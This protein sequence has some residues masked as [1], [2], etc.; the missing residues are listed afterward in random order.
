[1]EQEKNKSSR[2][3]FVFWSLAILSSITALKLFPSAP[4][5]KQTVKMLTQDGR[6]VEVEKDRVVASKNK[7]TDE[8]LKSWVKNNKHSIR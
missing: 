6:L 3:K 5:R 8:E 4:K 7:I 2:K 1:M